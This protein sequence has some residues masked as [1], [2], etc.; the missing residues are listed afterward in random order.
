M[1]FV[2]AIKDRRFESHPGHYNKIGVVGKAVV[3]RTNPPSAE[4]VHNPDIEHESDKD[5]GYKMGLCNLDIPHESG[6]VVANVLRNKTGRNVV[7]S[8]LIFGLE[9]EV[10]TFWLNG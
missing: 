6:I 5:R 1:H 7:E 8:V 3:G 10:R 2:V 9:P 4:F